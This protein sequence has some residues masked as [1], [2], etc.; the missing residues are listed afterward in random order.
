M[1]I[2]PVLQVG[3]AARRA[4]APGQVARI[5][6]VFSRTIY[7][8]G[9]DRALICIG[10]PGIGAGPLNAILPLPDGL[11]WSALGLCPGVPASADG[12]TL[13]VSD[14]LLFDLTSARPWRPAPLPHPVDGPLL[15]A[16][17]AALATALAAR[18]RPDGL[19][20][21]IAPLA[22]MSADLPPDLPDA[23]RLVR[24]AW[25]GV[26]PLTDWLGG[27]L[28]DPAGPIPPPPPEAEGLIGLGPGL[29]PSGD[30]FLGGMLIAL[31]ALGAHAA[32]RRLG[33]WV[34]A[35]AE[36][37]THRIS[38]GHLACAAE[39]EGAGALH[40][41]LAAICFPGSPGLGRCL[42]ALGGIGHSSG[43]DALAGVVAAT[44]S[45]AVRSEGP[46]ASAM[47]QNPQAG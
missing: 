3:E 4:L 15:V 35:Q 5:L 7:C 6:A 20:P 10:P 38:Q 46:G 14:H 32:A 28:R 36:D 19:G 45:L 39:G 25:R 30:D 17:L 8:D 13:R 42:E 47:R 12:R 43:W 29:T 21:L 2:F 18:P 24:A 31:H 27:I 16:G 33:P 23:S 26:R 37:R 40:E 41:A 22:A 9:E 44:R 1:R 11:N 34:L